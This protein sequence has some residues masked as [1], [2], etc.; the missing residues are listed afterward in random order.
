[1]KHSLR[2]PAA[3]LAAF[4]AQ[5]DWATLSVAASSQEEGTSCGVPGVRRCGA[6]GD[7]LLLQLGRSFTVGQRRQRGPG[8]VSDSGCSGMPDVEKDCGHDGCLVLADGMTGFSCNEY[9]HRS[10]R[11]CLEAWEEEDE[12]CRSKAVLQCHE[13]Y[14]TTSDLLCLCSSEVVGLSPS[15][16][17][18]LEWELVWSDEFEGDKVDRSKWN[19]IHGGGGFGNSE[20][21]HYTSRRENAR[22]QDGILSITARC[23]RYGWEHFTSAK[24]TTKHLAAWGPGHRVEVRARLPNGKGTWPAIWMLPLEEA[25]GAWPKSG[26]IDIMEAVG[27]S[28]G[29]VWGTVHT[30]AYNHMHNSQAYSTEALTVTEW[31]TYSVEWGEKGL[32]WFV[33]GQLFAAFSPSSQGSDKWPFD[34]QFYLILNLAVGGSWGGHCLHHGQPDCSQDTEF[35]QPQVMEVDFARVYALKV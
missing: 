30:G 1:M 13:T 23:E 9:C 29:K 26:E 19:F 11:T 33:D 22:V 20:L 15:A 21:Q 27:C 10:G 25:H 17:T 4:G 8:D 35:G 6:I 5:L 24:V 28:P 32:E 2:A 12:T 14:G 34:R 3:V 18:S 31:H 16:L 7:H